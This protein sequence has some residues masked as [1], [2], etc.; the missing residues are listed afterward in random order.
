MK[1]TSMT[2]NKHSNIH[3]TYL[4][5]YKVISYTYLSTK[6]AEVAKFVS[7]PLQCTPFERWIN[8]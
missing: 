8:T 4:Q 1:N 2:I 3:V 7:D 6:V 5:K